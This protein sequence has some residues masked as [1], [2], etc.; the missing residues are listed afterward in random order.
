MRKITLLSLLVTAFAFAQQPQSFSEV[1]LS[2]VNTDPI[3]SNGTEIVSATEGGTSTYT[4]RATWQTDYGTDCGGTLALEDF[5]ALPAGVTTCGPLISSAGDLCFAPGGVIDG[6]SVEPSLVAGGDGNAVGISTGTI[7]NST[8]LVGA[9]SF[10]EFT[11][12]NFSPAVYAAGMDIWN[13][14]DPMTDV[15]LFD[16]SNN[17]IDSF[18]L[19]NTVAAEDFFGFITNVAVARV[20]VEEFNGGGDLIGNLE[21]GDCPLSVDNVLLS[22]ISVFPNPASD[23]LN[24]KVPVGV[25]IEAVQMYDILGKVVSNTISNGEINV[26]DLARGVYILNLKT[27]AGTLTEK[28]IKR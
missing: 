12:I 28:I 13:N 11:I 15:R 16:E 1:D 25:E 24:V 2:T 21:F 6:F 19:N 8:G 17:L 26:A 23:I 5:S 14:S 20:E 3:N 22:Q 9:N 7:G 10:A 18:T 27:S 4:D